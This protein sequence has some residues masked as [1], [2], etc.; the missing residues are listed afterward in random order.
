VVVHRDASDPYAW[1]QHGAGP[2]L[3][4]GVIRQ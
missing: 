2:P 3:A 1:P 4:C